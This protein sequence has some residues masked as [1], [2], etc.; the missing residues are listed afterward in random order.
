VACFQLLLGRDPNP[1][2]VGHFSR[3]GVDLKAVV[4]TFVSSLEFSRRGM[5]QGSG[6]GAHEVVSFGGVQMVISAADMDVGACVK[7]GAYEPHVAAELHRRL[8]PGMGCLDIGANIGVFALMAARLV[9]PTGRVV[10]VEPNPDNVKLIEA[11]RR[12]NGFE[13]VRILQTAAGRDFGL[14]MLNA[15]FTNGT[16]ATLPGD[17]D[18]ILRARTVPVSP[19]DRLLD[20]S[21]RIDLIKID[22]EGGEAAALHGARRLIAR[23][24]PVIVSEFNPVMIAG[25]SGCS[26]EDYLGFLLDQGYTLSVLN[27][28]GRI[29]RCGSD[30][31]AVMRAHAASGLDHIDILAEP[32]NARANA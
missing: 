30:V 1:E 24:R 18:T 31:A 26:G 17:V 16:A 27:F 29:T 5:Q 32:V 25:I 13:Q 7:A 11:S 22:I 10:A 4:S 2:E 6:P 9:G 23:D 14:L 19:L 28:E 12:L 8:R 15:S 20:E 21:A 3:V